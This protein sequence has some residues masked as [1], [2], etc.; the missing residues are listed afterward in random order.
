M[1]EVKVPSLQ[2]VLEGQQPHEAELAPEGIALVGIME[3]AD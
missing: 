1:K 3:M 2:G